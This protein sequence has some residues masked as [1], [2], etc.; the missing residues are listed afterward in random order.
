MIITKSASHIKI[1]KT[2]HQF[3]KKHITPA[4]LDELQLSPAYSDG[5]MP[6]S[7]IVEVHQTNSGDDGMESEI[8]NSCNDFGNTSNTSYSFL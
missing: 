5:N 6:Q 2:T 8:D 7:L 3:K 4:A 1:M